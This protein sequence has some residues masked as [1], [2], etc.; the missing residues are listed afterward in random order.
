MPINILLFSDKFCIKLHWKSTLL[1]I[2]LLKDFVIYLTIECSIYLLITNHLPFSI[3][4][5]DVEVVVADHVQGIMKTNFLA[6]WDEI[7]DDCEMEDTYSLS[8]M[9][10]LDGNL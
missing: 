4:L 8:T 6:S 7:G 1:V 3:Q 9:K 10:D 5:E 2:K